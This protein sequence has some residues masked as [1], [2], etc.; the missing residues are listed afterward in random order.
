MNYQFQP[1]S[2][3][4]SGFVLC[5]GSHFI[6]D[7]PLDPAIETRYGAT[8]E[9]KLSRSLSSRHLPESGRRSKRSI[10]SNASL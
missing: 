10:R 7:I 9:D 5:L 4:V 6:I 1:V 8:A 2:A 3:S